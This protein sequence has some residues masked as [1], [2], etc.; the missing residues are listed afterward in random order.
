MLLFDC[1]EYYM[2]NRLIKRGKES[3]RIDDNI[4]AIAKK[5]HYYKHNTLPIMKYYDDNDKLVVVS[6][7]SKTCLKRPL[8]RTPKIG[9][10]YR[11]SL[12]RGQKYCRM[13][14]GEQSAI[15]LTS[16]KLQFPIK[17]L[18]LSIL[19]WPLK[20]GFTVLEAF[21]QL[22]YSLTPLSAH[23]RNLYMLTG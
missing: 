14:Q 22:A 1:E 11:S 21:T 19:K 15:L 18:V 17:T 9:F 6:T 10:Q 20:T 16:I 8:K 13:L 3:G 12:N 5:L 23:Q 2:Q 7:Y 4:S